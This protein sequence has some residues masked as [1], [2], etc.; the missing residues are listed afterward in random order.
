M[1]LSGVPEEVLEIYSE[2][3]NEQYSTMNSLMLFDLRILRNEIYQNKY[4]H[5]LKDSY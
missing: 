1:M 4:P 3:V 2:Q 5:F